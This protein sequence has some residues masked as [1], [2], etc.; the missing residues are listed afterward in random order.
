MNPIISYGQMESFFPCVDLSESIQ[1][2][3]E[4]NKNLEK[5]CI[6]TFNQNFLIRFIAK[7]SFDPEY[8][9]QIFQENDSAFIIEAFE[10]KAN[11]WY[12]KR[13]DSINYYCRV[14]NTEALREIESLFKMLINNAQNKNAFNSGFDGVEYNFLCNTDE[15]I[16]CAQAQSLYT[17]STLSEVL[18]IV[19]DLMLY[20][21]DKN[22]DASP[23]EEKIK[24]LCI[25]MR[26]N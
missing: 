13:P 19:D 5:V 22:Y 8:A 14:M 26:C 24:S 21:K 12:N 3:K 7:P 15:V 20:A 4:Y 16:K 18:E 10:M 1:Q 2:I 9:F 6:S 23:L 11:L 25:R 17:N